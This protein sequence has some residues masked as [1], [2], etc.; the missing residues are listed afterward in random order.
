[1]NDLVYF[2]SY[3]NKKITNNT[4]EPRTTLQSEDSDFDQNIWEKLREWS[5]TRLEPMK[6]ERVRTTAEANRTWPN[7]KPGLPEL[8]C[9]SFRTNR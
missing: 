6:M 1:M 9:L 7:D 2:R 4:V 5:N 3:Y 8:H